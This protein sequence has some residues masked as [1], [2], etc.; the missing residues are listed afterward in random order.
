ML[1]ERLS[2]KF[3]VLNNI[4]TFFI[5]SLLMRNFYDRKRFF[6]LFIS[7]KF[8]V[9][10]PVTHLCRFILK[11]TFRPGMSEIAMPVKTNGMRNSINCTGLVLKILLTAVHEWQT[12]TVDIVRNEQSPFLIYK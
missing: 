3:F 5:D 11:V 8:N 2:L 6:D 10:I 9:S 7:I 12:E 4:L 1:S